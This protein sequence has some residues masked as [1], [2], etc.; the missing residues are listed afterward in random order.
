MM[1]QKRSPPTLR[2]SYVNT[3]G[4]YSVARG[5]REAG[6]PGRHFFRGGIMGIKK[7]SSPILEEVGMVN[8]WKISQKYGKSAKKWAMSKKKGHHLFLQQVVRS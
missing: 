6:R 8:Q 3:W 2:R 1:S 5:V 4:Q 7:R